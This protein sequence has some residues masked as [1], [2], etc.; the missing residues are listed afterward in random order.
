MPPPHPGPP[1]GL[2]PVP[3]RARWAGG[4]SPQG[5]PQPRQKPGRA[6]LCPQDWSPGKGP[7]AESWGREW[8]PGGPASLPRAE[9]SARGTGGS[10]AGGFI[11]PGGGSTYRPSRRSA[12]RP[13]STAMRYRR[14]RG[15]G[16]GREGCRVLGRAR[17]RQGRERRMRRG[18][19]LQ[20]R[21]RDAPEGSASSEGKTGGGG[22]EPRR[23]E[24]GKGRQKRGRAEM[25]RGTRRERQKTDKA[26]LKRRL[27]PAGRED[28]C[29]KHKTGR[30]SN[31][32]RRSQGRAQSSGTRQAGAGWEHNRSRVVVEAG[33]WAAVA[34]APWFT[35]DLCFE[36]SPQGG[37]RG[38]G[39][40][41][42]TLESGPCPHMCAT[43]VCPSRPPKPGFS[44]LGPVVPC[45]LGT[46]ASR[47]PSAWPSGVRLH[48]QILRPRER[49][50]LHP[51][52]LCVEGT[53]EVCPQ[54]PLRPSR[55]ALVCIHG[56]GS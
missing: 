45:D 12:P 47:V 20:R 10:G 2:T 42:G 22:G 38:A 50:V 44:L 48:H 1:R 24:T 23:D 49:T 11:S 41:G 19:E 17:A 40:P 7:S 21:R 6:R 36:V 56:Q 52:P 29:V 34:S 9:V 14:G 54:S 53:L 5:G 43:E 25:E 32:K 30:H 35:M 16:R 31:H 37:L 46:V 15:R 26:S 4:R 13:C 33:V 55:A 28:G 8:G 51:G 27:R 3:V 18:S 39:P